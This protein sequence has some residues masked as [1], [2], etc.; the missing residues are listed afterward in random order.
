MKT[1]FILLL[2]AA[3][4]GAYCWHNYQR[5]QNPTMGQRATAFAERSREVAVAAKVAVVAKAEEWNLTPENIKDE[6]AK[7]GRVV[8]TQAMAASES[9]VDAR[10][11]SVLKGKYLVEKN[12]SSFDIQVE[13]RDGEVKL[14]G[15]VGSARQIGRAVGLALETNGVHRVVS[16]LAVKS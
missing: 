15:S 1:L 10:I 3:L 4:A 11:V 16:Y 9:M 8:R 5:S 2:I 7:T 12:L 14:A 6:L 13:C